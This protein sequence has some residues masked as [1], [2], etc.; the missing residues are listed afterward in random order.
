[1]KK[2]IRLTNSAASGSESSLA[3]D[4][5]SS[6]KVLPSQ[7]AQLLMNP[8]NAFILLVGPVGIEPT[9]EGL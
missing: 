7:G 3:P 6:V 9:T 5:F 2:N 4:C 1:M 8:R